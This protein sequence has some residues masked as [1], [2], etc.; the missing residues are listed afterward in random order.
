MLLQIQV[1]VM[2]STCV[3]EGMGTSVSSWLSPVFMES[4]RNLPLIVGRGEV[5]SAGCGVNY[6]GED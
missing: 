3:S 1:D 4:S 2:F 6:S 5:G